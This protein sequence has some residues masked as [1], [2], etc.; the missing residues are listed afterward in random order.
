MEALELVIG[1]RDDEIEFLGFNGGR[2][3]LGDCMRWFDSERK[4][5]AALCVS[6]LLFF[7]G[8]LH[9][10]EIW[11]EDQRD[12]RMRFKKYLSKIYQI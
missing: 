4:S 11:K 9:S 12:K 8:F 6:F 3:R 7:K 10:E 2:G 1:D 5:R